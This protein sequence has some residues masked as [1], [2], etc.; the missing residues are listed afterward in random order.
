MRISSFCSYTLLQ[1]SIC[2][3]SCHLM[4]CN[5][6]EISWKRLASWL[7][8]ILFHSVLKVSVLALAPGIMVVTPIYVGMTQV[9][10]SILYIADRSGGV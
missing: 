8:R 6:L 2:M 1:S 9:Q 4:N 10:N 7:C 5:P 3:S